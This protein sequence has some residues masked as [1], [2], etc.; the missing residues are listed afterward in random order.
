MSGVQRVNKT[1]WR[2]S[3]STEWGTREEAETQEK[4]LMLTNLCAGS[5]NEDVLAK[6]VDKL[7]RCP[8][9][10]IVLPTKVRP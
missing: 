4:R 9:I 2:C 10:I 1:F 5:I 8:Q 6:L 3:D 7:L